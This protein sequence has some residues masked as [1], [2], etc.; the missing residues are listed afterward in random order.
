MQQKPNRIQAFA[1]WL[2][3]GGSGGVGIYFAL[4]HQWPQAIV[5]FSATGF[6]SLWSI[7]KKVW[8]SFTQDATEE[9][10]E[11]ANRPGKHTAKLQMKKI[12]NLSKH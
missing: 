8:A 6:I 12:D 5:S 3:A 9:L 1:K 2:L 7:F 10:E 11:S 4:S